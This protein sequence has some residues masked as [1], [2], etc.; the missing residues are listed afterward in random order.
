MR[1]CI[2]AGV[3]A[4]DFDYR[5]PTSLDEAFDLL[6][7][8]GARVI[9]GGQSLVPA[10]NLRTASPEMLVDI[11]ALDELR[12]LRLVGEGSGRRLRI[13]ALVR[14]VDIERSPLVADVA[15]LLQQAAAHVAYPAV[16]NLGTFCGSLALGNPA[17]EFPMCAL[18]LGA[19][20]L[21]A[22]REGRR[23]LTARDFFVGY[24]R[25]ALQSNEILIGCEVKTQDADWRHG[26]VELRRGTG[27]A[28]VGV[29]LHGRP[30]AHGGL[31]EITIAVLGGADRPILAPH[32]AA[33]LLDPAL[34]PAE[35]VRHAQAALADDL[36]PQPSPTM[37]AA[38]RLHLARVLLGRA[39]AQALAPERGAD[40]G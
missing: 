12:D 32:A 14:H 17:S 18:A 35:R 21:I 30:A 33:A 6:G 34:A 4:R 31:T 28:S 8:P 16:R 22:S 38:T 36:D 2:G 9:A 11:N 15:P 26:F 7:R 29:R 20:L 40:V 37:T 25:T 39:V 23:T 19:D 1:L 27:W 3:K 10:L 5:R 24:E 13:G